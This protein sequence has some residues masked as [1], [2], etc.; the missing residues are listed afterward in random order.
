MAK[1]NKIFTEVTDA[2]EAYKCSLEIMTALLNN[3]I[4]VP[5]AEVSSNLLA[6][7][8]RTFALQLKYAEM[9]K[10]PEQIMNKFTGNNNG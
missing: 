6:N 4:S 5:K 2:K 9:T 10:D 1:K 8:N 7:A 3:Q